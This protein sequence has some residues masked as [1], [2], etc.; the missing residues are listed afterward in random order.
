MIKIAYGIMVGI[1]LASTKDVA[2]CSHA[3]SNPSLRN[4][5]RQTNTT[6][7]S[8]LRVTS[9]A[10]ALLSTKSGLETTSNENTTAGKS[11]AKS[12]SKMTA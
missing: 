3:L 12:A 5:K 1:I 2:V 11:R 9:T 6:S 8:T 4:T 10:A 7:G